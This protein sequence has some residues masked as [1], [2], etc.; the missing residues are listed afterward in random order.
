M[1]L[2]TREVGGLFIAQA[3]NRRLPTL[4]GRVRS[5]VNSFRISGGQTVTGTG[6]LR[7]L[8]FPY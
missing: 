4:G 3:V 2:R 1:I 8:R 5:Q 6:F 7:A